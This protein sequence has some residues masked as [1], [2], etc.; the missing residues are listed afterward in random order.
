MNFNIAN[1]YFAMGNLKKAIKYYALTVEYNPKN[2]QAYINYATVLMQ[3][4]EYEEALRKIR[5][6]FLIDKNNTHSAIVYGIILI[7]NKNY[8]EA[9]EKF[10]IAYKL[11]PSKTMALYGKIECLIELNRPKEALGV[12]EILPE[13]QLKSREGLILK[14]LTYYKQNE[15]DKSNHIKELGLKTADEILEK[16]PDEVD[17]REKRDYLRKQIQDNE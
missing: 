14:F 1:S 2:I 4:G 16:Y 6:A 17:I 7:K 3:N 13:E 5:S 9:L 12:F 8:R 11:D 15:L 10:E